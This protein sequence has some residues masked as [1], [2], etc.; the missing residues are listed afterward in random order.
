VNASIAKS[1]LLL[2]L[3]AF[4][5]AGCTLASDRHSPAGR[6]ESGIVVRFGDLNLSKQHDLDTLY[7]RIRRTARLI[8]G[9][10]GSA[11]FRPSG[12]YRC[13]ESTI[14]DAV[15]RVNNPQLTSLHRARGKQTR[16]G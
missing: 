8:C 16:A 2:T 11:W 12:Y 5:T 7:Q 10:D 6:E 9:S 1:A 13:L 15:V 14:D 4:T 3:G